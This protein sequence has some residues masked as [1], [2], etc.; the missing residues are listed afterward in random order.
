VVVNPHLYT[1]GLQSLPQFLD[2]GI[3][4]PIYI[5]IAFGAHDGYF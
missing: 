2:K 5:R 1:F 4:T 3:V